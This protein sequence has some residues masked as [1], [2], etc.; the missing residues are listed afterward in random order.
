MA[1]ETMRQRFHLNDG[2]CARL[3][4]RE[5]PVLP[6]GAKEEARRKTD[7][8][9]EESE[10]R[11]GGVYDRQAKMGTK[12]RQKDWKMRAGGKGIIGS[13][14]AVACILAGAEMSGVVNMYRERVCCW[15]SFLRC[16]AR[17]KRNA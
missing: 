1:F 8:G 16:T 13:D 7:E 5:K 11:E 6:L 4:G 9:R 14:E 15:T 17:E 3:A 10:R 12:V 2:V